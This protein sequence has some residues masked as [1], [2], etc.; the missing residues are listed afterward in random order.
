MKKVY[1]NYLKFKPQAHLGVPVKI[2]IV[3][4]VKLEAKKTEEI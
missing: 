2:Y 3:L 1:I 4:Y